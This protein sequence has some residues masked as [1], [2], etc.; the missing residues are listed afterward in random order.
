M[1]VGRIWRKKSVRRPK[2]TGTDRRRRERL[3]REEVIALGTEPAK[4]RM[5]T[6]KAILAVRKTLRKTSAKKKAAPA[7][8]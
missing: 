5:M 8:A 2:K 7:A 1:G 6:P 4:V 3:H